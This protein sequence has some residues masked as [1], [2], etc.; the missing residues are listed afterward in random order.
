M[1]FEREQVEALLKGLSVPPQRILAVFGPRQSG[2]TTVALQALS[3]V[4]KAPLYRAADNPGLDRPRA[5]P[6]TQRDA[7]LPSLR[8]RSWLVRIWE[9]ARQQAA[10]YEGAV[11][12]LD[13]IQK[14]EGWSDCTKGL[15]DEDRRTQCPLHLVIL[16]SAPMLM[17]AGLNESLTG[18]FQTIPVRH[19]SFSEMAD[20][21]RLD[22][23]RY[24]F[25]GGYP[26]AAPLLHEPPS[27]RSYIRSALVE[28]TLERDIVDMTRI[29]RPALLKRLFELGAAVS[30]QILSLEKIQGELRDQGSMA[31]LADYL[32]LLSRVGL[33]AG[34]PKFSRS[35]TQAVASPRKFVVLNTALMTA[36]SDYS[37]EEAQAD[38]TFWGRITETGVGAHLLNTADDRTRVYYWRD[39]DDNEVDFVMTRGP[40][41]VAVEVKSGPRARP[42]R[43]MHLFKQRF[44]PHRTLL[45]A[46]ESNT[47]NTVQLAEFLARPASD[48][49]E[50]GE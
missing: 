24:L 50:D 6:T 17:Q 40:R 3:R 44:Q 33:L 1:T 29:E 4:Q 45:V 31:T 49:F 48:W 21:F 47:Q 11:L 41:I 42:T 9:E 18:R 23:P 39:K 28:T 7:P 20:A 10:N 14:I 26:G 8:D 13:E 43:A 2:K 25:F 34:L 27:W 12:V 15:W 22:L 37:F 38:R 5:F 35:S 46:L 32:Q 19:W 36:L 30:G 16:G